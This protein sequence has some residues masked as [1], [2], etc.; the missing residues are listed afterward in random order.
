MLMNNFVIYVE[1]LAYRLA[2]DSL[3]LFWYQEITTY[4]I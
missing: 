4:V 2:T 3:W 1:T